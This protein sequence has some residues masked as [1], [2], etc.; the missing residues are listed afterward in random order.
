MARSAAGDPCA[1]LALS[2]LGHEG[3]DAGV[4][5]HV[6]SLGVPGCVTQCQW[7]RSQ[8]LGELEVVTI[9]TGQRNSENTDGGSCR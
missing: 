6:C 3:A 1:L 8:S 9:V 2:D 4:L 7:V 5:Q